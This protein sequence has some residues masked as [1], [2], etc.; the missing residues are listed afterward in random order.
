[1]SLRLIGREYTPHGLET[2]ATSIIPQQQAVLQVALVDDQR[3]DVAVAVA[4]VDAVPGMAELVELAGVAAP[5][6]GRPAALLVTVR[7]RGARFGAGGPAGEAIEAL[8]RQAVGQKNDLRGGMGLGQVRALP[9][10]KVPL[11]AQQAFVHHVAGRH[12]REE[13]LD[14]D[15]ANDE[16]RLGLVLGRAGEDLAD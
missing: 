7:Q 1:M 2:R 5:A 3:F 10:V 13:P 11:E 4:A 16:R 8:A 14:R 9:L 15:A 12:R 6:R